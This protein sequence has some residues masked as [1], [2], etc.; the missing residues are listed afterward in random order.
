MS[1]TSWGVVVDDDRK[2][3]LLEVEGVYQGRDLLLFKGTVDEFC[4]RY[5]L[6]FTVF[7]QGRYFKIPRRES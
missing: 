5:E 3:E 4:Q 6:P 7:K 2:A 1:W